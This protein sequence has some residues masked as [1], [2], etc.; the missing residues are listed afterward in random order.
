[1]TAQPSQPVQQPA[2]GPFR[3]TVGPTLSGALIILFGLACGTAGVVSLGRGVSAPGTAERLWALGWGLV[4]TVLF[5]G[6]TVLLVGQLISRRPVLVLDDAGILLPTAWPRR[7]GADRALAWAQVSSLHA[8][9]Q[10]LH[11]RGGTHRQ[12]YLA[13]VPVDGVASQPASRRERWSTALS[14]APSVA[15]LRYSVHVQAG[16]SATVEEVMAAARRYRPGLPI[17]DE[18]DLPPRRLRRWLRARSGRGPL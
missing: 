4:L 18:R 6:G 9:T 1:M 7:R 3:V 5:G 17:V 11:F 12:H 14:R 15:G 8:Y 16:W 13:F 2:A 10:L